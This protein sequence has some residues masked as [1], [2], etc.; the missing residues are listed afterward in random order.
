MCDYRICCNYMVITIVKAK[1]WD[2]NVGSI[3]TSDTLIIN[4]RDLDMTDFFKDNTGKLIRLKSK[5][6]GTDT[7]WQADDIERIPPEVWVEDLLNG[8]RN[9]GVYYVYYLHVKGWLEGRYR[10]RYGEY[11]MLPIT[12]ELKQK[13]V[14]WFNE[15]REDQLEDEDD[16]SPWNTDEPFTVDNVKL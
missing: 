6:V 15:L 2:H 3:P 13:C 5:K 10:G 9:S 7:I 14:D 8:I 4:F 1:R 11:E 12:D 16:E